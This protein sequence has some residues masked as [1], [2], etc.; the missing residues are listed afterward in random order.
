MT[1]D[2]VIVHAPL[3]RRRGALTAAALAAATVSTFGVGVVPAS[4][5]T[6]QAS[7]LM[8]WLSTTLYSRSACSRS[9]RPRLA[10]GST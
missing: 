5:A 8:R 6:K 4:A 10:M 1:N 9:R 7:S 3:A 2:S